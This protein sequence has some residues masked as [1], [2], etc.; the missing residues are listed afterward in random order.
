MEDI[1]VHPFAILVV[2]IAASGGH[3]RSLRR[4][5]PQIQA[6]VLVAV[7]V[8]LGVHRVSYTVRRMCR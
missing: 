2:L 4:A 5:S 6:A 1:Q 7:I 8:G 3:L